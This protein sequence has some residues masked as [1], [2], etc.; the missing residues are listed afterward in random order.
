MEDLEEAIR[1]S[2]ELLTICPLG[3]PRHSMSL[4]ALAD[5]LL[6]HH[7]RSGSIEDL[8]QYFILYEQVVNDSAASS[9]YR[10]KAATK[11][12]NVARHHHHGS[13]MRAYSMSLRLLDRCLI[14]YPNVD[15]QQKFLATASIPKSLASDAASVAIDAKDLEA[16]VEFLEQGRA[17]LWSKMEGYRHPLDQLRQVDKQLADRLATLNVELEHLALSSESRA[18][19]SEI[20]MSL[21][22]DVQ[23]KRHR[24]LSEEL[25]EVVGQ[26]RE[27]DGFNSFLQVVPFSTLRMAAAEGPVILINISNYRSDA[28]VLHTDNPPI[29]VTLPDVQP[30]HLILLGQRLTSARGRAGGVVKAGNASDLIHQILRDLWNKIVSPVVDCLSLLAV[31]QKSRIWWCP[32]SKLCALPLHAAGPYRPQQLNL[33]DIYTSSYIPTLSSLIRARSNI[34]DQS[35]VPKLLVIGQPETLPNVQDEINHVQQ[36]GDFVD[37]MVGADAS[38]ETVL[39]GLQEHSWS[40]FACHGHLGENGQPF[41]GSFELHDGTSYLS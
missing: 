14:S 16:A 6:A 25:E 35:I 22:F 36:L 19:D 10:I 37:V 24:I 2:R 18:M 8:D 32:T 9:V 23:M 13:V 30:E 39:H 41:Q 20:S 38:R 40:H 11:W 12:A 26:I 31:P 33:P 15:S 3:H 34:M 7:K 27:I 5:A 21:A 4:S 1:N 29:L 17:I 28:I